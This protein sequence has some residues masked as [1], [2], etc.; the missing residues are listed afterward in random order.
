MEKESHLNE[1]SH[2]G[3][4]GRWS[5]TQVFTQTFWTIARP[6]GDGEA[7][8]KVYVP[9]VMIESRGRKYAA[10]LLR[11]AL[12]ALRGSVRRG[13]AV[14]VCY[15]FATFCFDMD[16]DGNTDGGEPDSVILDSERS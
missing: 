4:G 14:E 11:E 15:G 3:P 2:S 1:F 5:R 12:S 7:V 6:S 10:S 13:E 9:N 8:A 16:D